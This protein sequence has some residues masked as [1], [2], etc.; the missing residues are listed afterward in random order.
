MISRDGATASRWDDFVRDWGN[1]DRNQRQ[2]VALEYEERVFKK[3]EVEP[4]QNLT[5]MS[6]TDA[7]GAIEQATKGKAPWLVIDVPASR[8]GSEVPL[9]YV[10]ESQ[11]RRMRKDDRVIGELQVSPVWR[12]YARN[13]QQVAGRIRVY[14]DPRYVDFVDASLNQNDGFELLT[15]VVE[16]AAT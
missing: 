6:A 4:A 2:R 9:N 1:L 13:L 7:L 14:C 16:R 15:Q 3:L 10:V 5:T 8:P 12:D 11:G